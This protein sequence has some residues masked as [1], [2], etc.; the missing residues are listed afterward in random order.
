MIERKQKGTVARRKE[1]VRGGGR[2]P[3]EA[4]SDLRGCRISWPFSPFFNTCSSFFVRCLQSFPGRYPAQG[5]CRG[6]CAQTRPQ[7]SAIIPTLASLLCLPQVRVL[8]GISLPF[9]FQFSPATPFS[10]LLATAYHCLCC[11]RCY[12]GDDGSSSSWRR[13]PELR[14]S[15]EI[16]GNVNILCL[17]QIPTSI[18]ERGSVARCG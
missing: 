1:K 11:K 4:H 7:Q 5:S 13:V 18:R 6:S 9:L 15:N 12:D 14:N 8:S 10:T 2:E 17:N 3:R 16:S